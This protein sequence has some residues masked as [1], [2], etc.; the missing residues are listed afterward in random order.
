MKF[1]I[2]TIH[3]TVFVLITAGCLALTYLDL[4]YFW[5]D[6][7]FVGIMAKNFLKTGTLTAWDGRNLAAYVDGH[8]LTNDLISI[9]PPLDNLVAAVSF[10]I[11][12]ASSWAGRLP[13]ALFGL[14]SIIMFSLILRQ[15]T[16]KDPWLWFYVLGSYAYSLGFLLNVRQCRYYA[17]SLFFS[18]LTLFLYRQCV[19][20]KNVLYFISLAVSAVLL[21]YSNF[22]VAF[23]FLCSIG[24]LH[25]LFYRNRFQLN[26][27]LKVGLGIGIFALLTVPYMFYIRIWA[28]SD[29]SGIGGIPLVLRNLWYQNAIGRL[30]WPVVPALVYFM[31]SD[32]KAGNGKHRLILHWAVLSVCNIVLISLL[33]NLSAFFAER[34]LIMSLPLLTGLTGICLRYVHKRNAILA[35]SLFIVI[36]TTN[37]LS[38]APF[39]SKI[40]YLNLPGVHDFR[41]KNP[42]E[43][44]FEWRLPAYI[45]EIQ[46]DYPTAE[47]SVSRF[48]NTY[49]AQ[50]DLV[51]S[52]SA[53]RLFSLIFYNGDKVRICCLLD[54]N[55]PLPLDKL[56]NLNAPL[57]FEK[58]F[59]NWLIVYG[60]FPDAE[61]LLSF[62][63][64]PHKDGNQTRHFS[65]RHVSTLNVFWYYT[66]RPELAVHRFGPYTQF[67][68][69]RGEAVY[70]FQR[71]PGYGN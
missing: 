56:E 47:E 4:T 37:I 12:G 17:L 49:A 16:E 44:Q 8:E 40:S 52:P 66:H 27:W 28:H 34:Y 11:F 14:A 53:Y 68:A 2:T 22:L 20:R 38:A 25:L 10:R 51:Y 33:S 29:Y 3:V 5:D 70:M 60:Y 43:W 46:S 24:L 39:G 32:R 55:T 67:D 71:V 65:Y 54:Q 23:A 59:P 63:S 42:F 21:F 30:P 13:F 26:D 41:N 45:N 62:F 35:F 18:L 15:D 69:S 58:N 9:N 50:D 31:I 61:R 6:E 48:L 1:K 57:F 36:L 7:A 19:D 64:R